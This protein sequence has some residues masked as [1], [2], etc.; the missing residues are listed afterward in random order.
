MALGTDPCLATFGQDKTPRC[1][2]RAT[3]SPGP[4]Y[5]PPSTIGVKPC[6]VKWGTQHASKNKKRTNRGWRGGRCT[7]M[8]TNTATKDCEAYDTE[9]ASKVLRG[10]KGGLIAPKRRHRSRKKKRKK[11][12][13]RGGWM[14][15]NELTAKAFNNHEA[16]K[17]FKAIQ[18]EKVSVPMKKRSTLCPKDNRGNTAFFRKMSG[19]SRNKWLSPKE[20]RDTRDSLGTK[21][22]KSM[23]FFGAKRMVRKSVRKGIKKRTKGKMNYMKKLY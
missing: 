22:K 9:R 8:Q 6:G 12:Y 18:K 4:D 21:R 13:G 17:A 20:S 16:E 23:A 15:P 10:V 5:V 2:D 14:K 1:P 7:W 11:S 19:G 3:C